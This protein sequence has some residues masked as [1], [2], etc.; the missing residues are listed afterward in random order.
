M[1]RVLMI[2]ALLLCTSNCN[3]IET[4]AEVDTFDVVPNKK[5]PTGVSYYLPKKLVRIKFT[6]IA[7]QRATASDKI[8]ISIEP[9]VADTRY[10]FTV[11]G[12]HLPSHDSQFNILVTDKGLLSV[13]HAKVQDRLPEITA[14]WHGLRSPCPRAFR[15]RPWPPQQAGSP[16]LSSTRFRAPRRD[17]KPISQA[18][19]TRGPRSAPFPTAA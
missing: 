17:P 1:L 11:Q 5:L 12:S 4:V 14:N 16:N 13:V 9:A 15:L 19:S 18:R 2:A 6:R 7:G 8:D 10:R 3:S